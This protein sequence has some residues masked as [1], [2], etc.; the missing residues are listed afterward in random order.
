MK[1]HVPNADQ[2]II[3]W[4]VLWEIFAPSLRLDILW[5][6]TENHHFALATVKFAQEVQAVHFAME[7][8]Y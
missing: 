8:I 6:P 3:V 7:V 2:L 1:Q 4:L 5:T